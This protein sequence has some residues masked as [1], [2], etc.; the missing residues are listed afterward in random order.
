MNRL[1]VRFWTGFVL[2]AMILGSY[3]AVGASS[4]PIPGA[5]AKIYYVSTSGNDAGTGAS[6]S[7][8][9]TIQKCL[10]I[11]VAGDTCLV[12]A[13]T[14]NESLTLKTSG[15]VSLPI[16]VKCAAVGACTV[17]SGN[18]QTL[19]TSNHTH[20]YTFDGLRFISAVVT[21]QATLYFGQGT[22]WS[23]NDKT[24]GNNGFILR[25]CYVE[26]DVKF[27]GHNNLVE[28][29]EFN[30]KNIWNN[31]I[32]DWY[33]TSYDNTYRNNFIHGYKVRSIW[34]MQYTDNIL[35]EGNTI[36]D[37]HIDCD[38]AGHP[39]TRCNVRNN[40]IHDAGMGIQ[41]ENAFDSTFEGNV[42]YN[43]QFGMLIEN[44]GLGPD[45]F[46]DAEYRNTYSNI[47]VRNNLIYNVTSNGIYVY[48]AAGGRIVNNTIQ[49][50]QTGTGYYGAIALAKYGEY[51]SRDWEVKNNILSSKNVSFLFTSS[52]AG[53][54][55]FTSDYNLY[56]GAKFVQRIDS[57]FTNKT[58]PQWQSMGLDVHGVFASPLFVNSAA[59][60]FRL[61]PN[62]PACT[63][64]VGGTYMGAFPCSAIASTNTS[65]APSATSTRAASPT[66]TRLAP[67]LTFTPTA[68]PATVT[69][70]ASPA[71]VLP[72]ATKTATLPPPSPTA[73]VLPVSPTPTASL[74]PVVPTFTSTSMPPA[75]ETT[76]DDK[77]SA[78]VYSDGWRDVYKP[79]AYN[80]S[81]KQTARRDTFLTF[82]FTGQS[83]S[84]VYKADPSYGKMDVY[85]DDILVGTID[86]RSSAVA[87]QFRWD[88]PGQLEPGNH[89]LK[90]VFVPLTTI[91]ATVSL[92]AV[93]VR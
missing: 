39:V 60:D 43:V 76:Y 16:T 14:Y 36:V 13:G 84:V 68:I 28:N 27:Y 6:S 44:Y 34:S 32:T 93:I 51:Y 71:P 4:A 66:P 21:S 59:G 50:P 83:F 86:E 25:N 10:N 30:G 37:G 87:F 69:R 81:L 92:D 56:D 58:T 35:I 26:G 38:G 52:S 22:V 42:I 72:T 53:L 80:G 48:G 75:F 11:V 40:I 63:G 19:G 1:V 24:L 74:I 89:T 5:V 70:T 18:A 64:G 31:G 91:N 49:Y 20:Y 9:R 54:S 88:Y 77:D 46:A 23:K 85:V 3:A 29:C 67:T 8:F 15:T 17:N 45:F 79:R 12:T 33:A 47:T 41:I 78:F 82:A 2:L 65:I 62:S 7:P 61:Q 55:G 57:T 90:L 73:S